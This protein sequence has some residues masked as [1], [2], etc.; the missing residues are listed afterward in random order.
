LSVENGLGFFRAKSGERHSEEESGEA[1]VC[2]EEGRWWWWGRRGE[3]LILVF[4]VERCVGKKNRMN[5]SFGEVFFFWREN[6][7]IE[8]RRENKYREKTP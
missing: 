8:K 1:G 6:K 2:S 4:F 3:G 7:Y 5:K